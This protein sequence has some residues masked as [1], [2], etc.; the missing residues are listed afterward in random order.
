MRK[1][2]SS[3]IIVCLPLYLAQLGLPVMRLV[4]QDPVVLWILPN[5][6]LEAALAERLLP[7]QDAH[8]SSQGRVTTR[9]QKDS[10]NLSTHSPANT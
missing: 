6:R 5:P 7:E 4:C 1:T 2:K 8:F 9:Q 10:R 3:V